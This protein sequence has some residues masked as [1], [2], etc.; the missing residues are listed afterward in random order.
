MRRTRRRW[1]GVDGEGV[2]RDPH[3]YVLMASS[4]GDVIERRTGLHTAECLDFL[5]SH[6]TRDA[7]IAGYY[8]S[9][10]WTMILRDLPDLALYT[11]LRPELRARPKEEGGGF[12]RVSWGPY[13]LHYL[14]GAVWISR[15][16]RKV[17]VWDLG[18]YYQGPFVE[19][20]KD[21]DLAPDVRAHIAEMKNQRADFEWK[22]RKRVREYCL[23]EC[24]AL[25]ELAECLEQAHIDAGIK[26]RA[27][28]GPG[29]TASA[30]LGREGIEDKLGPPLHPE[31]RLAA[32]IAYYGGRAEISC[33]GPILR[34]VHEYDITSAYPRHA[35][36]LPCLQHGRW[37]KTRVERVASSAA[38]AIVC[39]EI[40][41][42][43][44]DWGPLPIRLK[45]GTI[46]YPR[47]GA[48]GCWYWAEWQ[49]A[50]RFDGRLKFDHAYVYF[51]DCD[52]KPFAFLQQVYDR[53][54][55]VG[56]KTGE[57]RILKLGMNSVYGK[58]AQRVG[59]AQYGSSVW[60]GMITSSTR[61]QLLSLMLEH[62][63]LDSVVMLAT[64]GLYSTE[65]I[66][67]DPTPR[68]G[69]WERVDHPEGMTLVRPGIYWTSDG[70]LRARGIGRANLG[71]AK[72]ALAEGLASGADRVFLPPRTAFGGARLTVYRTPSGLCRS[73]RYGQWY[74]IPTRVSLGPGPKR[75]AD[76]TPPLLAG[77]SSAPYKAQ[78]EDVFGLQEEQSAL[79]LGEM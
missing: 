43:K 64:D 48:S 68:L 74:N 10:D 78:K 35:R 69:A 44:A 1:I 57:G 19:A 61:A 72:Q 55:E 73:V 32:A 62:K 8:L 17:T 51:T 49:Q 67:V 75:T 6:G 30:L 66:A 27:W 38:I 41:R 77:V 25:A 56:K 2:G 65:P 63:R 16:S 37:G 71:A 36:D 39:G 34:P 11:L 59:P 7:R 46:V 3:R 45:N 9:Y 29:S 22:D 76:W 24:V 52:C 14:A 28:H 15:G 5:L 13:K 60:A 4:D 53:R 18:K 31:V 54:A 58:L 12:E 26:P 21:W 70:V 40:D 42:A 50:R 79:V 20:L 33:N 23:A 47:G